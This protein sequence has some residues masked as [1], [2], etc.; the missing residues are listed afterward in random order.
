MAIPATCSFNGQ[1]ASM[2]ASDPPQTLAIDDEP[3]DSIISDTIRTVYG[4]SS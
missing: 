1:P 2:R 3:F 4:N